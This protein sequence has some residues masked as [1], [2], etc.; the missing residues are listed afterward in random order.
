[1]RMLRRRPTGTDA[2]EIAMHAAKHSWGGRITAIGTVVALVFSA[3]SLWE[4]SLKQAELSVHIPGVVTY[5]RDTTTSDDIRPSG[6]F[7]VLA[8]PVTIANGGARDAAVLALQLDVKN[9]QTGL[10]ARFEATYTAEPSYFNPDPKTVRQK[11]PFS[12]LVIAG[13]SAWRGTIVFYPVSYSNGK[14]LTPEGQL[15]DFYDE[16]NKLRKKYESE[17]GVNINVLSQLREKVPNLPEWAEL[18][19]YQAKVLNQ[20]DTVE[21]TLK[22][23]RP[24][25]SG[26]FDRVLD[27][28]V[29]PITLTLEAPSFWSRSL[30]AGELV[31]VRAVNPG[32]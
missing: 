1:M 29:P 21:V 5:A 32:T 23:V 14:A 8:V 3:F 17:L 30:E 20:K 7:E 4:T 10:S 13:R 27:V 6:G 26:W 19:A 24:A 9:L 2:N 16:M 31:R 18:D 12:A 22:L 28:P 15:R 25:P 11:A